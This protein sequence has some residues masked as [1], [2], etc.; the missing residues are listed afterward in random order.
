M[1]ALTPQA[2][3][4]I[5]GIILSGYGHLYQTSY[6][7]LRI[8]DAARAKTWLQTIL[9]EISTAKPW[10]QRPDGTKEKPESTL[11]IAFTYQG[12]KALNLPQ[13]TLDT[14]SREFIEGMT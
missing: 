1:A 4:D 3:E 13:Y 9:P 10:T 2:R 7:F 14:F 5:Q 8:Q 6:L 11:N 12:L